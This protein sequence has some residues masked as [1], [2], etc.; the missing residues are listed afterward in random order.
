L[1]DRAQSASG[2]PFES[3]FVVDARSRLPLAC[4]AIA[5]AVL[6]V[7]I[8]QRIVEGGY[9]NHV[10]GSWAALADDFA[11]GLLYRPLRSELGYGGTRNFPLHIVLHGLLV[12]AGLSL[13]VAGHLISV[14][15][16]GALAAAGAVGLRRRGAPL[17]LAC[18]VGVLALA[19]RTAVMGAAGIRGDLLP[20]ALGVMGLALAPR[21]R[22]DSVVGAALFLGLAVLAKPTL[23]WAP[24]GLALSLAASGEWRTLLRVAVP[25]AAVTL[26]G[27]LLAHVVS[28]GEMLT[29]FRACASGGGFSL[30]QLAKGLGYA[31]PGDAA[32]IL[33]GVGL[34]AWRGRRA[35]EHPFSAAAL[36]CL[37]V[38]LFLFMSRGTHINHFVD[39]SAIGALAIGVALT[40]DESGHR[41][42]RIVLVT[43]TALGLAEAVLLD[44][45]QIK[46]HELEEV[47]AALPSGSGPILSE[48][49]WIPLLAGERAYVLDAYS[50]LQMR[51]HS[52]ALSEDF[53]SEI[54]RC[55][56]RAV[57]LMGKPEIADLWFDTVE[58]GPGF[59]DHILSHYAFTGVVGAHAFY[60]PRCDGSPQPQVGREPVDTETV[61]DRGKRASGL[62]AFLQ[63]IRAGQ[64]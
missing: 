27:L 46:R 59:R 11:H 57:V 58:F 33:G 9:L 18:A 49:P 30:A 24:A 13:K 54:D 60:A 14:A 12:R 36:I 19:S 31:R 7:I 2:R 34:T 6:L 23:L 55:R 32:W 51:E 25:A 29:S 63:R 61:T 43:A 50:L 41:L 47:V 40:G 28:H 42:P 48:Q 1:T 35:L 52:P 8:A 45:I 39:S 20:V 15:S 56:F 62:G 17:T 38:T 21:S 44:G 4:G 26:A 3:S 37:P 64:D 16:A 22:N 53:L 5:A 10:S